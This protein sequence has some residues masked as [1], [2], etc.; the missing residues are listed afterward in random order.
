MTEISA[1]KFVEQTEKLI[2]QHNRDHFEI[3]M[4]LVTIRDEKLYVGA[5]FDT[6]DL[7]LQSIRSKYDYERRTLYNFIKLHS[8]F[9]QK[10]HIEPSELS[11]APYTRLLEIE[12]HFKN[13]PDAEVKEMVA[14][15]SDMPPYLF[16]QMK[17]EMGIVDTKPRMFLTPEGK[18]TIEI[19][20]S[21]VHRIT[22]LEDG[23][24]LYNDTEEK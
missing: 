5:G 11:K 22:N 1:W 6:F 10:L 16:K 12:R 24:D 2:E 9:V 15:Q 4:R 19:Y 18:W 7:Y 20:K 8:Y 17:K 3:G 21:K 13:K 14:S 23:T